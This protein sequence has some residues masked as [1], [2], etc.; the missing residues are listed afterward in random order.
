MLEC[1]ENMNTHSNTF[2][3]FMP[4][5]LPLIFKINFKKNLSISINDIALYS[6]MI[7]SHLSFFVVL[8]QT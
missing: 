1:Y 6:I 7:I 8:Y 5:Q 3:K 4:N 2:T